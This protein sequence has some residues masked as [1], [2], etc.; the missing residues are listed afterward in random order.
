M[1]G[2]KYD[3]CIGIASRETLAKRLFL[4]LLLHWKRRERGRLNYETVLPAVKYSWS[5]RIRL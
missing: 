5:R 3:Q 4:A 2:K 1:A